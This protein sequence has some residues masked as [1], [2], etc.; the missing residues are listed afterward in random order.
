MKVRPPFIKLMGVFALLWVVGGGQGAFARDAAF[1]DPGAQGGGDEAVKVDPKAEIDIGDTPLNVAKRVSVFFVNETNIPVKIE[2]IVVNGDSNVTAEAS[3]NDCMKQGTIDPLS[4]CSIEISVTPTSP[5]TWS[6]DV[7]MT[8]NGAGRLTRARLTGKT[9]GATTTENKS[10]GLAVSGKDVKPIDFGDVTVGDGKTVRS[11]LMINDS[12]EPITIYA[13]DVIEANN[14][15]Q[16]LDQGCAVDMELAPGA[17][18]PVTLLWVPAANGPISTDLIIRHSGKLGFA[19]IPI[20]GSAK[21]GDGTG[22]TGISSASGKTGDGKKGD[23]IPLPPSAQDLEKAMAGKI[24][25]VS[26][27]ALGGNPGG[28]GGEAGDGSLHLIGTVGESAL[29][30]KGNGETAIVPMGG[31]FDSGSH[32]IKLV[33][34]NARSADVVVEGKRRSY[35]L[36]AAS[37]LVAKANAQAQQDSTPAANSASNAALGGGKK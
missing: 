11:T 19:V 32:A 33:A 35:A 20:R 21:G 4:R 14:G 25:P 28:G 7:L 6:V 26:G 5:G 2:K 3:A 30:L 31:T 15:L 13:I 1:L 37:S 22:G 17:S 27:A 10:T 16:K 18:C 12:P 34:V 24:S 8:H 23:I 29:F 36:E 9:A